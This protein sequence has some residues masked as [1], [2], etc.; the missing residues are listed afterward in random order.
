MAKKMRTAQ[1]SKIQVTYCKI[2]RAN[3]EQKAKLSP[4]RDIEG[5]KDEVCRIIQGPSCQTVKEKSHQ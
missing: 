2:R 1:Y 5:K 4:A 3:L